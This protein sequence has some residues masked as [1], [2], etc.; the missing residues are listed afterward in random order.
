MTFRSDT[1]GGVE[2]RLSGQT[3]GYWE[4]RTFQIKHCFMGEEGDKTFQTSYWEIGKA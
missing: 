2:T 3:L 4:D 1:E